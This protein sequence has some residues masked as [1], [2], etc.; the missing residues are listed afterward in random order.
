M[1]DELRLRSDRLQW[2]DADGEVL[3]LDETSLLYLGANESGSLLWQ[4]LAGGTTREGLVTRLVE[5]YG[6][7]EQ[8]ARSDLDAFLAD[9]RR[10][11]LLA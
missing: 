7:D 3:A 8:I 2:L 11:G 6:I 10:R 9:L 1:S 5:T 4:A